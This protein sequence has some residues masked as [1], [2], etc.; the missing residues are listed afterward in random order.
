MSC[1]SLCEDALGWKLRF[2]GL[3]GI[4]LTSARCVGSFRVLSPARGPCQSS[5][6]EAVSPLCQLGGTRHLCSFQ[7]LEGPMSSLAC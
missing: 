5:L 6:A 4:F 1:E 2:M 7:A 3:N